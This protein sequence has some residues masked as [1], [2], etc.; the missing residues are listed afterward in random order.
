MLLIEKY[1][2]LVEDLEDFVAIKKHKSWDKII[3]SENETNELFNTLV[4]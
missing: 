1:L 4:K 3:L 2:D